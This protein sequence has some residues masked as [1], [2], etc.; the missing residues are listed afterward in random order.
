M[1]NNLAKFAHDPNALPD[2][3][4]PTDGLAQIDD[5]FSAGNDWTWRTL[6]GETGLF[7]FGADRGIRQS[8]SLKPVQDPRKLELMRCAY[9]RAVGYANCSSCCIDCQK[10]FQHFY[11]GKVCNKIPES[12]L[13]C[14]ETGC[15]A[16]DCEACEV[17]PESKECQGCQAEQAFCKSQLADT[18]IVTSNCLESCWFHVGCADCLDKIRKENPCCLVGEHCGTV[19]WVCPGRGSEQL[20]RL[21]IA[22]LDYAVNDPKKP[23]DPAT[24]EVIGHYNKDGEPVPWNQAVYTVKAK[25]PV[26]DGKGTAPAAATTSLNYLLLGKEAD[27]EDALPVESAAPDLRENV[28]ATESGFNRSK[29]SIELQMV[30]GDPLR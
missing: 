6:D 15:L 9:Q 2:F 12:C 27:A 11:T 10:R 25:L 13:G 3:G 5:G 17:R 30:P 23:A 28:P 29:A 26:T 7:K 1:L 24:K 20:S 4:V 22:I 8:W 14:P 18:G 21:T 16:Q 19:V